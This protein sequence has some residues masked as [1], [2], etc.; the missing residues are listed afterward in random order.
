QCLLDWVGVTVAGSQEQAATI[1]IDDFVADGLGSNGVTVVGHPALFPPLEA[2]LVNGT[3]SHALDYDDVNQAIFGHPTVP[4]MAGLLAL[5]ES[6]QAT[7]ADVLCAFVAGYETA[8]RVGRAVGIEHYAR[9]FHATGTVGTFG[10]A[11]ACGHL[12]GLDRAALA[13]DIGHAEA[14]AAVTRSVLGT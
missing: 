7:G 13:R 3:A 5:A 6:R 4:I 10:A 12:L 14:Q 8:C 11:A 2:A 9:G 1:L